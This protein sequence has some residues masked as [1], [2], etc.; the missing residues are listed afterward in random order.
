[1]SEKLDTQ[2]LIC[3][4]L[5]QGMSKK[6]SAQ[7][8]GIN[9]STF[10]RWIKSDASFASRVQISVLQYKRNLIKAL[11]INSV[12]NGNVALEIL[13]TRWPD[14]WNISK[15]VQVFNYDEEFE[16]LMRIIMGEATKEDLVYHI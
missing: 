1:M 8:S 14:E 10:Y 2:N 11:N 7:L 4:Y 9:E 6:D 15:K 12:K 5:T 3:T 16:R 13:R